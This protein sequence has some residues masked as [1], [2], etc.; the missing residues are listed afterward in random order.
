MRWLERMKDGIRNGIR[1]F[2][3]INPPQQNVFQITEQLDYYGNAAVNRIWARGDATELQ[4]L[5]KA[6]PGDA[7][8]VRFWAAVPTKGNDIN[9]LHTGLPKLMKRLLADIVMA[10]MGDIT[11]DGKWKDVWEDI[12][13]DNDFEGLIETALNEMLTVG[14]GAFKISFQP[15]LTDCP[16][17]EFVPGDDVEYITERGRL[18][19]IVFRTYYAKKEGT[20]VLVERYGRNYIRSELQ[21]GTSPASLTDIEETKGI[22]QEITYAGDFIMAVRFMAFKSEKYPGRGASIFEGKADSFDSLDETWSQWMDALR[23][24]RSKE[25]IPTSMLPVDENTGQVLAPNAFDHAFIK[26]EKPMTEGTDEK[27]DLQQ[28]AIPHE[29]YMS[30][31]ITALDLCLQG[32]LS[33]STLGI[34]VKKLDNAEAQR[35]KEKVTLYTRNKLVGALQKV[36]PEVVNVV[37][38][39]Y[40]TWNKMELCDVTVDVPFGE[41]A[42]PSFESQVETVGKGKTQGVMS[43]EACV[44]EL[45]GDSKDAE[46]KAEEV[47]RL[48]AEQGITSVEEPGVNEEANGFTAVFG[49]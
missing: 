46:W 3:Q 33:P 42:N 22:K 21:K 2:L 24:G 48:K 47:A 17:I 5:Y 44:E 32:V 38:K 11:V 39:A 27:I 13:N 26:V 49:E 14:D 41:Y 1:S 10:D 16:I 37:L 12:E 29:S 15:D 34:D 30:T 20:F 9:K 7:N 43:V 45:Y 19:E 31:Y 4:E 25:Y 28:P 6:M 23:R 35:E 8:K 18:K 36:I 40:C